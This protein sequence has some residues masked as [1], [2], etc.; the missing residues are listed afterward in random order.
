[1]APLAAQIS[2]SL[3]PCSSCGDSGAFAFA[4]LSRRIASL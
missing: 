3:M 1:L 4:S 2:S